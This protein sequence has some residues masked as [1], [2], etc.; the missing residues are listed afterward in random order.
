MYIVPNTSIRLIKNCPL[1]NKYEHTIFFRTPSAQYTYFYST[2]NGILFNNQS[3]QRVNKNKMRVQYNAESLY[4]VNYLMFKNTSFG[5]KWFY[6]FVNEVEYINNNCCEITYELDLMQTWHFNYLIPPCYID[7]EH[8]AVD[9][10]GANLVPEGLETG[11]Y[12]SSWDNW[13]LALQDLSIV[14]AATFDAGYN[15][16]SGDIYC[17][18]YAGL[19]YHVFPCD[20]IGAAAAE[21]LIAGAGAKTSGIVAMFVMPTAFTGAQGS[22]LTQRITFSAPKYQTGAIDG[23]TPKNNKLYTYPYNFL[24]ITNMQGNGAAYP[25]EYFTNS[26]DCLFDITGD[27][28][29]NPGVVLYPMYYKGRNENLDEKMVLSG[30]PQLPYNIDAFKAWLAQNGTNLA[31]DA[32]STAGTIA[33]GAITAN[34]A[35]VTGGIMHVLSSV[36]QIYER[37]LMPRQARGG[38]GSITACATKNQNFLFMRKHVRGEFAE[39]IDGFFNIYGYATHK[40][41]T[42]NRTSRPEWNYVK[43]IGCKIEG[44]Y[45]T[46]CDYPGGLVPLGVPAADANA[47]ENIY[48]NGITFWHVPGH[49]ANYSYDN[50]PVTLGGGE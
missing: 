27:M 40:V 6:A 2:L 11:D 37:S 22:A 24:Y 50:T 35:A 34:P 9:T 16:F 28:S 26:G 18:L 12:I 46:D 3:Y 29:P 15:D 19:Y 10:V 20:P 31:V 25:Y 14:I 42:P 47:I 36:S 43:T 4:D 45:P 41:K 38:S 30:Y 17:G 1:D 13:P 7:R 49:V 21:S 5:D 48:N 8:I 39:I 23:Y 33:A 32:L 44:G